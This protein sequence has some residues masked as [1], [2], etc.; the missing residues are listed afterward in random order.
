MPS[1]SQLQA[2]PYFAQLRPSTVLHM[3]IAR[4]TAQMPLPHE[5][6]GANA[7]LQSYLTD[8]TDA[9]ELS[10]SPEVSRDFAA[11]SFRA[12]TTIRSSYSDNWRAV[13]SE[14]ACWQCVQAS[15]DVLVQRTAVA[16]GAQK[17]QMRAWYDA[18]LELGTMYFR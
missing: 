2:L 15:L 11:G 13:P 16:D 17:L 1:R 6:Q 3:A 4:A 5:T 10:L 9:A 7:S 12:L 14:L 8:L 18:I